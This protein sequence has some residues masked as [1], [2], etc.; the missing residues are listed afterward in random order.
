VAV[1]LTVKSQK[2]SLTIIQFHAVTSITDI[3]QKPSFNTQYT[4]EI[5]RKSS[6]NCVNLCLKYTKI[7]SPDPIAAIGGLLLRRGREGRGRRRK[8]KGEKGKGGIAPGPPLFR[9]FRHLCTYK[10][11]ESEQALGR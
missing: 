6:Q 3:S 7:R 9:S 4:A 10:M 8:G 11:D 5:I 1:A 2:V